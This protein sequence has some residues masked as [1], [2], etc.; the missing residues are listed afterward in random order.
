[1]PKIELLEIAAILVSIALYLTILA[2]ASSFS[3]LNKQ[4]KHEYKDLNIFIDLDDVK[5]LE[6][7]LSKY[8]E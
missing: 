4:Q 3:T 7:T 2:Y 5:I 6:H 8:N 1:M